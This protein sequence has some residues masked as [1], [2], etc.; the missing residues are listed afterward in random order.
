MFEPLNIGWEMRWEQSLH[1]IFTSNK[2]QMNKFW[3]KTHAQ[4]CKSNDLLQ[5]MCVQ[6]ESDRPKKST[7]AVQILC[8]AN[9]RSM[10]FLFWFACVFRLDYCFPSIDFCNKIPTF[11]C[12]LLAPLRISSLYLWIVRWFCVY[13]YCV[14]CVRVCAYSIIRYMSFHW[15]FQSPSSSPSSLFFSLLLF[16]FS[17]ANM[18]CVCPKISHIIDD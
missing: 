2:P 14:A 18:N 11:N 15:D 7:Q 4:W 10:F 9:R 13:V 3:V 8:E 12:F 5:A 1:E 16:C 6:R 17:S